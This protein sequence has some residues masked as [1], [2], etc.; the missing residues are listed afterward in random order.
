M[1]KHLIALPVIL[2]LLASCSGESNNEAPAAS[3]TFNI[4]QRHAKQLD[5]LAPGLSVRIDDITHGKTFLTV[6]VDGETVKSEFIAVDQ[7]VKAPVDGRTLYISCRKLDNHLIGSDFAVLEASWIHH[8]PSV[9]PATAEIRKLLDKIRNSELKFTRNGET[10]PG[11]KA[12]EFLEMKWNLQGPAIRTKEAFIEK[13]ATKSE[14]G[15]YYMVVLKNG[16]LV[17]LARWLKE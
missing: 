2:T 3:V 16:I 7:T 5:K 1:K 15:Q 10:F 13:I 12:A 8:E 6:Y 9:A 14:T 4:E 17:P 11:P